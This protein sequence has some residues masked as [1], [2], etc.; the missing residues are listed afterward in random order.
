MKSRKRTMKI[1]VNG[2][3]KEIPAGQTLSTFLEGL[4]FSMARVAVERNREIVPPDSYGATELAEGDV[5][6]VVGFVGGG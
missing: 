1:K 2:E 3:V 5:L 4:G 6:E